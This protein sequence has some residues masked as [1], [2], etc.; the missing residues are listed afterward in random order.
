MAVN[1]IYRLYFFAGHII[2]CMATQKFSEMVL[3]T[4]NLGKLVELTNI[5]QNSAKN[6]A[7]CLSDIQWL[8]LNEFTQQEALENGKSFVENALIKARFAS[9]V[10][11]LPA[12]ADDSGLCVPA[13]SNQPG[14]FS[15]R[16]AGKQANDVDNYQK[17]LKIMSKISQRQA[18]Y[19]CALAWVS[20]ADD[21]APIIATA[22]WLGEITYE[23]VGEQGFGYDPIFFVSEQSCTVAQLTKQQKS[24]ISH[25]AKAMRSFIEIYSSHYI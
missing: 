22:T 25:R 18:Y 4:H 17:L 3:A 24:A 20:C 15:A 16:F 6:N 2:F 8:S 5:L 14:I 7:A 9:E 10:S 21:P 12:L 19:Y 1:K 13:L 11:V 23:P